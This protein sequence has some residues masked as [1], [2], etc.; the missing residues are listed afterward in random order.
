M[1]DSCYISQKNSRWKDLKLGSSTVGKEGCVVCCA[2]MIICKKLAISDDTGKLA[3]IKAVIANCTNSNGAFLYTASIAYNGLTFKFTHTATK[4]DYDTWP[5]VYYTGTP[6]AVLATSSASILD[7]GYGYTTVAQADANLKG[8]K[9]YWTHTSSGNNAPFTCDTHS[10]VGIQRGNK[11]IARITCSLYPDVVAGTSG[12]VSIALSSQSGNNFYFSFT[13]IK[14][15]STGIYING[16]ASA[17]FICNV[18]DASFICDTHSTVTINKGNKYQ[19]KI[20]CSVPPL[21]VA[22]TGGIVSTSLASKS[23]NDY[24]YAFTGVKAGSTG[25]YINNSSSAVFI[26][27]VI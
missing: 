25:I 19:A 4:P 21:V 8:P 18:V 1:A 12:I 26:C 14:D 20:T 17:V 23:G 9:A 16:S 15:G 7:P 13:G 2:A 3:V 10:T 22:G 24:Y 6:H 5:I 27:K 11:Y